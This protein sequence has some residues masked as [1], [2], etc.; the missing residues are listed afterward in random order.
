[1]IIAKVLK[2]KGYIFNNAELEMHADT[3]IELDDDGA[4]N[5]TKFQDSLEELDDV[6]NVYSNAKYPETFN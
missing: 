6:Q 4:E 5:F 1:M 2:D 3:K